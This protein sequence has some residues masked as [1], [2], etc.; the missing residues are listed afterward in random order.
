MSPTVPLQLQLQQQ[1]PLAAGMG[2]GP[3]PPP[4]VHFQQQPQQQQPPWPPP[5]PPS[6]Q[7]QHQDGRGSGTVAGKTQPDV[8]LAL[9]CVHAVAAFV[10]Q[11]MADD[12]RSLGFEEWQA[13]AAV[14]ARTLPRQGSLLWRE[15]RSSPGW[16]SMLVSTG[17]AVTW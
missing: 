2:R 14:Q 9:A 10:A 8:G 12:L 5:P 16:C 1:P 11:R 17:L 7:L 15:T 13:A 3:E 4:A 6:S